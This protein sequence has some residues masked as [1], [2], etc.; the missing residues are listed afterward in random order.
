MKRTFKTVMLLSLC[1][2]AIA[3]SS[4]AQTTSQKPETAN[5][6]KSGG[7]MAVSLRSKP[8]HLNSAIASGVFTGV[9]ATQI[10]AFL[11]RLNHNWEYEPYLAEKWETSQDGLAVTFHLRSG[12]IFHDGK[13][14]TSE[15]VGFSLLTIQKYHPY[16]DMLSA[17]EKVDTPDP[18]TA[19]IRLKHPHP[20]LLTVLASPMTPI[21]PKH[22]YG[23]GQDIKTHPANLKPVGSGPFKFVSITDSEIVLEKFP[24]F[25]LPGR[26]Y[27]DKLIFKMT[28][29]LVIPI[30]LETGSVHLDGLA[31]AAEWSSELSKF[32][33][34]QVSYSGNEGI[35][36]IVW[37]A[38]NLRKPP[39]NDIRVRHAF[40]YTVDRDFFVKAC[41]G[42]KGKVATGPISPDSRFY[43]DNVNKYP[44]NT[45]LANRLLDE[46]GYPRNEKGIRFTLTLAPLSGLRG[47]GDFNEYL[48]S[49]MSRKVGVEI[50][51]LHFSKNSDW[52]KFV[53]GGEFELAMDA[54][55]NWADPVI[56]VHR[57]YSSRNIRPVIWTN[58][59]AYSNPAVDE[60][61]DKAAVE[62]DFARRKAL[63]AEF[64]KQVVEDLPVL[65]IYQMPF[66]T[67][68]HRNLVGVDNVS[69]WGIMFPFTDVYWKKE[70]AQ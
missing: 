37:L 27:L 8:A 50:K 29:R 60:L 70:G 26:P 5:T 64:Q 48:K 32:K 41:F 59:Q 17:V 35:G 46:A 31:D 22:V 24:G 3:F 15:D 40:A 58:T 49:V 38:F 63:Y 36:A 7:V 13:P 11:L 57:T 44:V 19:V 12:V 65:W 9:P 33:N 1:L 34:I 62:T 56:G 45:D 28:E 4:S 55:F 61:M 14:L 52:S 6:P 18:L 30:G 2:L 43:S 39:L 23:D 51:I 20:A 68:H 69:V 47:I 42:D 21:L 25:F 16:S 54:V 66:S 10:F 67:V 53:A